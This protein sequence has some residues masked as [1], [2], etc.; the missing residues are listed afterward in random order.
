MDSIAELKGVLPN[1]PFAEDQLCSTCSTI[2]FEEVLHP[3]CDVHF[4][5]AVGLGTAQRILNNT[6]CPACRLVSSCISS[7][8]GTIP[9]TSCI[10]IVPRKCS[11]EFR[12][13]PAG[14]EHDVDG[15]KGPK[16][17][18]W[19][20][21]EACGHG[22]V[23]THGKQLDVD[24]QCES[25][26]MGALIPVEPTYERKYD[27][28]FSRKWDSTDIYARQ[29]S[30]VV[31]IKLI[32]QWMSYCTT[33]HTEICGTKFMNPHARQSVRL[34]DVQQKQLV[35]GDLG[36]KYTALSYVWGRDTKPLLTK[37]N[38][39]QYLRPGGFT[40]DDI[41]LTIW[42]AMDLVVDL[43]ERY[44]WVD[45]ACIIQDDPVDKQ[46]KLPMMGEI[47]NHAMLV[48][49][50]AVKNAHSGLPGRGQQ[51][52]HWNRPKEII[53]GLHFT[54]GQPELHYKLDTT[55]WNT[56]GWTYQEGQL[57]R[58][59]LIFTDHEV[60]WNCRQE[61]WCEDRFTE[62]QNVRHSPDSHNSLFSPEKVSH[63]AV[64]INDSFIRFEYFV[65]STWEYCQKVQAFSIRSMSISDDAFW[66][67]LG[68]LKS[69][70]PKFPD[71]YIWGMPKDCLDAALLWET[72]YA[73]QRYPPLVILTD[74]KGWQEFEIPS[75]SWIGK[76]SKVWY[77]DVCSVQSM[78]EWHEPV[79]YGRD[80]Q[81]ERESYL[82]SKIFAANP[83]L[84]GTI[85]EFARLQCDAET[86][87]LSIHTP[88][89]T[90]GIE[91][92]V[93]SLLSAT[94]SLQSGKDIGSIRVPREAFNGEQQMQGE[95]ILLS[96]KS[97]EGEPQAV[98][99][100]EEGRVEI[101]HSKKC[102]EPEYNIM[103]IRFSDNHEVAYRV[104]WT[105][106]SKSAWEECAP[107]K[108][109]IVLG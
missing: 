107:Q 9:S 23:P 68:I 57:A 51:K 29:V 69:L 39:E 25:V 37:S 85:S 84:M 43:G 54:T 106:I 55:I 13:K 86:A 89:V 72:D 95:F 67:I 56:R 30:P 2:N 18:K 79:Q 12:Q 92:N 103:L 14:P 101:Q 93:H 102:K 81:E 70:L 41:P 90:H 38:L 58:R 63:P 60:Y 3:C 34:I 53:Q 59:A 7:Y 28:M 42:D 83:D 64:L 97:E 88:K 91:V 74:T 26:G 4:P 109:R 31:D 46:Q 16:P 20:S 19:L 1:E 73:C 24:L 8:D 35:D 47:Y 33:H 76:G 27:G 71:G 22:M 77:N 5:H 10:Q 94:V 50:A 61:A 65:C 21:I 32:R 82:E 66:A 105:K 108:K 80:C 100:P 78:V 62:F 44:L 98:P 17:V 104:A 87:I 99:V 11:F 40:K 52:R 45:S 48:I 15:V 36:F 6:S 75:W 96:S 49:I